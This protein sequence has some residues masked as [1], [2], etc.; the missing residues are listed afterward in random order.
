MAALGS[1]ESSD[2]TTTT[3]ET[4]TPVV[5]PS[6]EFFNPADDPMYVGSNEKIS[7]LL[8]SNKLVN[9]VNYIPCSVS[10]EIATSLVHS[11]NYVQAWTNLQNRFGGDNNMRVYSISKEI[12]L[13]MQG[14]LTVSSYFNKLLQLWGDEDS[15]E[16]NELC[17]LGEKC[18]ST[19]CMYNKKLKTRIQ[20]FL[21]GPNA[22]HSQV[23]TQIL[24]TTPQPRLDEAYSLVMNDEAQ[25]LLTKPI[26]IEASALY[27]S[28]S[29]QNVR[30]SPNQTDQSFGNTYE[31]QFN[32]NKPYNTGG[33]TNNTIN[34]R[35][36]LCTNC[37]L[38]GHS[39]ETCYKLHGYPLGHR[40]YKGG[41]AQTS[42]GTKHF[43]N[44]VTTVPCS[45]G[46]KTN[47]SES[48]LPGDLDLSSSSQLS[49]G[50][51][52]PSAFRELRS[53][54]RT[55]SS[56]VVGLI[57]TKSKTGYCAGKYG[58]ETVNPKYGSQPYI[59]AATS[60]HVPLVIR[61][62]DEITYE[63]M[64]PKH[65]GFL[66]EVKKAWEKAKEK[67]GSFADLLESCA[68]TLDT[69]NRTEFGNVQ[70]KLKLLE[71]ELTSMREH[72]RIPLVVARETQL[73]IERGEM[74]SREE[75]M[76]ASH[77][78]TLNK[79][80]KLLVEGREITDISYI[81]NAIEEYYGR[82]YT[83]SQHGGMQISGQDLEEIP[84]LITEEMAEEL[85]RPYTKE[86]IRKALFLI[87][88]TKASGVDGYPAL[89]YQRHWRLIGDSLYEEISKFLEPG[90]L[91]QRLNVTRVVLVPECKNASKLEDFRPISV[92]NT[93]MKVIS[94]A[95]ANIDF[96]ASCPR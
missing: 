94:K 59:Y 48:H 32:N 45:A 88:P 40:L 27:S 11:V 89:F 56:Q 25:K 65:E 50:L 58:F 75:F 28:Y 47:A 20:K 72:K 83:T 30:Q 43:T 53:V 7:A 15:Y 49:Q 61:N 52:K 24:S 17:D 55:H 46:T 73:Q 35:Q 8:V 19:K 62:K 87:A 37:Q 68:S 29:N 5:V 10:D 64:W 93:T 78:R 92:C 23:R 76:W 80:S 95:L 54:I 21:I 2:S 16:D 18:K 90:H 51:G 41:S 3:R 12:S 33:P 66:E 84:R 38:P 14:E 9:A 70:K 74:M 22:I 96:K 6:P 4:P 91:D 82:L 26:V 31:L 36:L 85:M 42:K 63:S 79:I 69:W 13:L 60:D 57:E 86:E 81:V 1:L 77:R 39:K 67:R 34:R 44:S 71:K